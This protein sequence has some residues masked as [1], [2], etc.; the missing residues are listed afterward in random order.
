MQTY[1]LD[2][3]S[4][5]KVFSVAFYNLENLY[6]I[7]DDPKTK[8]DEFT[9]KGFKHWNLKRYNNKIENLSEVISQTGL[10]HSNTPPV[11]M[12]LAEVENDNVLRDLVENKHLSP[13]N[14]DFIHFDSLD[15]R[16]IEVALLFQKN[17]FEVLNAE[18][19]SIALND[20]QGRVDYT[21][22]ILV[23]EGN[24][25]NES[26]IVFVNH[27]HS[28]REGAEETEPKRMVA[29]TTL[30][31]II[32]QKRT[33]FPDIKMIVMGDFND[34][35]TNKSIKNLVLNSDLYNPMESLQAHNQG[36]SFSQNRW[37]LFDQIMLSN[38]FLT[39]ETSI[40]KFKY[41]T[42]FNPLFIKIWHGKKK[43]A[44]F[45]S[46]IGDWHQGGF[47]DHFPV[48]AYFERL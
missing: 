2:D 24:L 39:T 34:E 11:L 30:E 31:K 28:R 40:F 35:S 9:P 15:E 19:Y 26:V 47:S 1:F 37:Y 5:D 27:W 23:V 18:R 22:D 12:G 48:L 43:N 8:D 44:P 10:E 20:E 25:Y 29:A 38:N 17:V 33:I 3:V 41:V 46:Y 4:K 36:S 42:V 21:R 6:D 7:Y 14:Y 13:W 32:E 45:R 16:G